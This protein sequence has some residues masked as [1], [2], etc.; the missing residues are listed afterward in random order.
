MS[1]K[2]FSR[3]L[4]LFVAGWAAVMLSLTFAIGRPWITFIHGWRVELVASIFL[5][6]AILYIV[7]RGNLRLTD[8]S[9]QELN[10]IV[11]PLLAMV[12][13][14]AASMIW[15]TSW[16]SALHY[17][18]IWG[19]FL[20]FFLFAR[21]IVRTRNGVRASLSMLLGS[22]AFVS[23]PAFWGFISYQ[24]FGGALSTGILFQKYGEQVT[25]LLPLT[26]MAVVHFKGRKFA[27]GVIGLAMMWL[28]VLCGL[29]RINFILFVA[30][31]ALTAVFA[32]V[33]RSSQ[34]V[35]RRIALITLVFVATLGALS[36][37]SWLSASES[38]MA[39]TERI[40]GN[41]GTASSNDFRKLMITL[42]ARMIMS[43]PFIGVGA[44]NF[45]FRLNEFRAA[46]GRE[47]PGD[48]NLALAESEIPERAHNEFLQ[49]LAELGVIGGAIAIWLVFG[50]VVMAVNAWKCQR[51]STYRLAALFGTFIFLASS[52]VSSYS[53][54]LIHHGFVFFFLLAVC[55]SYF[56][57]DRDRVESRSLLAEV[58]ASRPAL[59]AG[60]LGCILLFAYSAIRLSSVIVTRMGN[61]IAD[62]EKA[63]EYYGLAMKLDNENPDA[64]NILAMRLFSA[65]QFSRVPPLLERSAAIG[66][67][68]ST[69]LS[70]LAS[71]YTLAG[72]GIAAADTMRKAAE[73]YPR[74]VFVLSRYAVLAN[75]N[76]DVSAATAALERAKAIDPRA[77]NT[78]VELITKGP[79]AASEAAAR[80]GSV[81]L[82]VMDLRPNQAIYAVLD[83]RDVNIPGSRHSVL[84]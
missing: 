77:A 52:L 73:L 11:L 54:R 21:E 48:P 4:Y 30:G 8:L 31:F 10:W 69:D 76:G 43:D 22:L 79:L 16:K 46:Y 47:H 2:E 66:K 84:R 7:R 18:T 24:I 26:L 81:Y 61:D 72:D 1:L 62:L 60:L 49:I 45:G 57:R 80:D 74:S 58:L 23:I 65:K 28:L 67:A 59:V 68:N 12:G 35:R 44:D 19:C 15:A 55:S 20:I 25:A 82:K 27:F 42:S 38:T 32:C 33:L 83:E 56:F 5:A 63:E 37:T 41:E 3:P 9:S 13:W 64:P 71:S 14:S 34:M 78:W 17:T 39:V 36:S 50:L 53:F 40:T 51:F 6:I 75:T 70:Y 29:G